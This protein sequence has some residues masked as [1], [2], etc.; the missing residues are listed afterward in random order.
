MYKILDVGHVFWTFL[1]I[2]LRH[3]NYVLA[4]AY[5]TFHKTQDAESMLV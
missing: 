2:G 1:Y 4:L 5:S 3:Y